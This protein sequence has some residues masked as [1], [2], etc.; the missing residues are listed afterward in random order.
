MCHQVAD[1]LNTN[2]V[3]PRLL[4][5]N[6][7]SASR[8]QLIC[9]TPHDHQGIRGKGQSNMAWETDVPGVSPTQISKRAPSLCSLLRSY[10][11]RWVSIMG[12]WESPPVCFNY[13][14][15]GKNIGIHTSKTHLYL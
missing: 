11:Y 8:L 6:L 2:S 5:C 12:M 9:F 4:G 15:G 14:F 7:K 1:G 13:V 3:F 10:L